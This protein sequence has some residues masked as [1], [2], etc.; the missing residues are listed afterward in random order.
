MDT[1][2]DVL[3]SAAIRW[4]IITIADT[5]SGQPPGTRENRSRWENK[6]RINNY[7]FIKG[8]RRIDKIR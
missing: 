3:G 7:E 4:I 6:S 2:P 8:D 5:S 1:S